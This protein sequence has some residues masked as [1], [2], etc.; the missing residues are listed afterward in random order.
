MNKIG[1][2]CRMSLGFGANAAHAGRTD[3]VVRRWPSGQCVG[4]GSAWICDWSEKWIPKSTQR[5]QG[6]AAIAKRNDRIVAIS[7][8]NDAPNI[9]DTQ[10]TAGITN[11]TTANVHIQVGLTVATASLNT[12]CGFFIVQLFYTTNLKENSSKTHD[13][14]RINFE[15]F[16]YPTNAPATYFK[17]SAFFLCSNAFSHWNAKSNKQR[18]IFGSIAF[19][20]VEQ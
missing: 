11:W 3:T 5:H 19:F 4:D 20:Y 16:C 2:M 1:S 13:K 9:H 10:K 17:L 8:A 6:S 12:R 15:Y 14:G 18:S 7:A